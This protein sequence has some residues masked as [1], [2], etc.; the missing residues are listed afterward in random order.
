MRAEALI[1]SFGL[2][3]VFLGALV[4]AEAAATVGG[5]LAHRHYAH[6]ETAALTAAAGGL[7]CDQVLY[8]V[9][10]RWGGTGWGQRLM[11]GRRAR[12]LAAR[13][14]AR[15]MAMS[16][17]ARFLYGLHGLAT[18]VLGAHRVPWP[19]FA[20]ANL[21][22]VLAWTHLWTLVGFAASRA[23]DRLFGRVPVMH[24]LLIALAVLVAAALGWQ[25]WRRRT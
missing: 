22:A 7:I 19:L 25:L 21:G 6:F 8:L 9:G 16:A 10:R 15:P 23:F 17:L 20:L 2:T 18:L 1:A 12:L 5:I 11:A 3:G 4:D 24:V 14:T 13:I